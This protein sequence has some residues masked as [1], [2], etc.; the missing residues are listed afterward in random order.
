MQR[1]A[2]FDTYSNARCA[3]FWFCFMLFGM[4]FNAICL[5][6]SKIDFFLGELKFK[7][8]CS[9]HYSFEC[10]DFL[11]REVMYQRYGQLMRLDNVIPTSYCL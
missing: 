6:G 1:V 2:L 5:H 9:N 11:P 8:N 10:C 4:S 7:G 3:K